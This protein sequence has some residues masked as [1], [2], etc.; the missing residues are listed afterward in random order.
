MIPITLITPTT[1][2]TPPEKKGATLSDGSNLQSI[3]KNYFR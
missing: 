3:E 2:I 1:L